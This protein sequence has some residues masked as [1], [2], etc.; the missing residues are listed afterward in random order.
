MVYHYTG[1][2]QRKPGE[3]LGPS[4]SRS[5]RVAEWL[6]QGI[7]DGTFAPGQPLVEREIAATLGV[8]KTPVREALRILLAS[9]LVVVNAYQGMSVR[10]VDEKTVR[11]LYQARQVIEP[12]AVSLSCLARDAD[13]HVEARAALEEAAAAMAAGQ[14]APAGLANRRFHRALYTGC[15]N[16][17]LCEVLDHMQD[18]TAFVATA[19]WRRRAT[20]EVEAQEHGKILE[21]YEAGDAVLVRNLCEQHICQAMDNIVGALGDLAPA[22]EHARG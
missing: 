12:Q 14:A 9:G 7:L 13:R 16:R 18:L 19:G 21:A 11:D 1:M 15:D 22:Q 5:D 17:V 3:V 4:V 2:P 6:L 20:W 8:S 10:T